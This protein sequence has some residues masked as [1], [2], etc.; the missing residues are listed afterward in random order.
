LRQLSTGNEYI[1]IPDIS[2]LTGGVQS[3]G[4]MHKGLRACVELRGGPD[5]PLLQP[6]VEVGGRELPNSHIHY[7]QV[8]YWVPRFTI[9]TPELTA[10]STVFAPLDRRGFICALELEN[11]S[12]ETIEVRAGWRGCWQTS[13]VAAGLSRRIT[14]VKYANIS[15]RCSAST[16]AAEEGS[17]EGAL[18]VE[19]R[20]NVPLYAIAFL[21]ERAVTCQVC[22]SE[23]QCLNE[24]TPE[25]ISAAAGSPLSYELT[26]EFALAPSEKRC[27]AIYVG[28]GLE[29]LSAAASAQEMR[30]QG[31]QRLL[32]NLIGWLDRHAIR[33]DDPLLERLMNVNSFYNYFYAQGTT[34]DT[35]ELALVSARSLESDLCGVYRDRDAMRWSLPGV[36][37]INWAQ[38]RKMLIYAFTTQLPNVGVYSRFIDGIA[39]EP[40][41]AL[42]QLCAPLRALAMYLETT[43]DMSILFDRRVQTGVNTIKDIV[44]VQRNPHT[45]LFE[46]LL[47]PSGEVAKYPYMCFPNVLAW[48]ILLDLAAL[49]DRIKD[50]DRVDEAEALSN[51]LRAEIQQHFVVPGPMGD[52]FARS[53]DLNGNF[54]LG[55]DPE[56]SLTLLS[57]FGFCSPDDGVYRNTIAWINSEYNAERESAREAHRLSIP[58]LI[59]DLLCSHNPEALDFLRRAELDDGIACDWVETSKGAAVAGRAHAACAGFLAYGLRQALNAAPPEAASARKQRKPTGTL[60]HP[61]PELDQGSKK[62]RV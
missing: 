50:L 13:H 59:N 31:W 16:F 12:S 47:A 11:Q 8:S 9:P 6:I 29:E 1:S 24:R 19:F 34:L 39:L 60:Y 43:G 44:M 32:A 38:A 30:C 36:L 7:E 51:R 62:A 61:P 40:G 22:N 54:E 20:G 49:Y 5:F 15:S 25:G 23:G 21:P 42:D 55:D 48:R 41:L 37:H 52:M 57:Y 28:I 17:C 3:A 58:D 33:T 18:V 14:G 35:E 27:L 26:E 2:A 46:T 4:F 53:V 45:V 56:G 10:T